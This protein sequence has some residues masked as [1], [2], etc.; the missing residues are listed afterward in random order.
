VRILQFLYEK[1]NVPDSCEVGNKIFKKYFY[2]NTDMRSSDKKLFTKQIEKIIWQYSLKPEN[3]NIKPYI[4]EVREYNEI[5][6]VEVILNSDKKI[7]RI[8]E[9]VMRTI[10]YPMLLVFVLENKIQ[11]WV[12]HQRT[13]LSDSGKNTIEEFIFTDWLDFDNL[14]DRDKSLLDSIDISKVKIDNFY[15]L[16]SEIINKLVVYKVKDYTGKICEVEDTEKIKEILDK[17]K[18]IDKQISD[19]TR[20]LKRETQFNAKVELNIKLKKLQVQKNELIERLET[21]EK[22]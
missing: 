15:V 20:K 14:K 18:Y 9:I 16:Y 1:L 19:Y 6:V 8:A 11:L 2:D 7:K 17:I 3:I 13:S 21:N 4:D 22:N 12:A 10:P 5:E